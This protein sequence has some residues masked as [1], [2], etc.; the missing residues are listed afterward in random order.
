VQ[1]DFNKMDANS[2]LLRL[3]SETGLYGL[4]LMISLII[5]CWIFKKGAADRETW[6]MSNGLS[7][8]III[9]LIRQGHYFINGFPLFLW[10]FYYLYINNRYAMAQL[11]AEARERESARFRA[12]SEEDPMLP[13]QI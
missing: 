13:A 10:M 7:L 1:I 6:V 8:I 2:M 3:M 9:Y 5:R 11:K 4:I 12:P